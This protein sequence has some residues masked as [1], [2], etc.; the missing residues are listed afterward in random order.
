MI[1][2]SVGGLRHLGHRRGGGAER[3]LDLRG[4]AAQVDQGPACT[5]IGLIIDQLQERRDIDDLETQLAQAVAQPPARPAI[6]VKT[7]RHVRSAA[8]GVS[9]A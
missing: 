8:V 2:G 4:A 3:A 5:S 9:G 7:A 1:D 6:L